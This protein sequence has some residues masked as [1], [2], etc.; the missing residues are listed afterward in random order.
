MYERVLPLSKA[1]KL[2]G[3]KRG[4]KRMRT[5]ARSS[6]QPV[7]GAEAPGTATS[8]CGECAGKL[9][10]VSCNGFVEERALACL[11][12]DRAMGDVGLLDDYGDYAARGSPIVECS[13]E[14][15]P[16]KKSKP[17]LMSLA[18]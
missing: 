4:K 18:K 11:A 9:K 1:R 13:A 17:C 16:L 12:L 6:G 15:V 7:T 10:R 14:S 5:R 2:E 8:G 3:P